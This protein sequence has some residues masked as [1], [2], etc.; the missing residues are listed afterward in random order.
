MSLIFGILLGVVSIFSK[1]IFDLVG[2][3]Q[4]VR[5]L[6]IIYFKILMMGSAF[7]LL[8]DTLSSF[9]SGRGITKPVMLINLAGVAF[10]IPLNYILIFGKYGAPELGMAGSAIATIISHSFMTLLY[11]LLIFRI[12]NEKC[13]KII[14]SCKTFDPSFLKKYLKFGF[15]SGIQFFVDLFA[16][17]YV[18]LLIGKLGNLELAASNMAFSINSI[19]FMPM[20]GFTIAVST[21][22]GQ[23]IGAGALEMA[24]SA[25]RRALELCSFYMW[26]ISL[27]IFV[28]PGP[29]CD[30]F[31]TPNEPN[32]EAV[33]SIAV[34]LM[35]FVAIYSIF[36]TMNVIYSGALKG[37]GDTSFIGKT[38]LIAS[39]LILIIPVTLAVFY[40]R[41][42]IFVVWSITSFYFCALA[43]IFYLRFRSKR[44]KNIKLIDKKIYN[45]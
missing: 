37:A 33:K 41:A 13:F 5:N 34:Y 35:R 30:L 10:N 6:E 20:I 24:E 42:G 26:T 4:N 3:E 29:F 19:I 36:D 43:L 28:L 18:I 16:F 12:K 32:Y 25:V 7:S 15:P 22:V 39:W 40:F 17:E 2:H 44:W 8:H 21:L 11:V 38:I 23:G 9:Y 14:S 1:N 45:C 31:R 27:I